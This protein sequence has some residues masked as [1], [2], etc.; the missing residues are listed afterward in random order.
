MSNVKGLISGIC[1]LVGIK[2]VTKS[3]MTLFVDIL[4]KYYSE[5]TLSEIKLAFEFASIGKLDNFLPKNKDGSADKAHYQILSM[6]YI[7][8]ILNAYKLYR[9]RIKL[10]LV[11]K[12][13]KTKALK[14]GEIE[15]TRKSNINFLIQCFEQY[16]NYGERIIFFVPKVY[17]EYLVEAG[18]MEY[19]PET[20]IQEKR[21]FAKILKQKA[22]QNEYVKEEMEEDNRTKAIYETFDKLI[23]ND[24]HLREYF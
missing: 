23:K 22:N 15:K 9:D 12:K 8:K 5:L 3:Q 1:D 11:S 24:Q 19:I 13:S 17:C 4:R 20:E 14:S 21:D 10:D 6:N 7:S 2:D 16:K 18:L